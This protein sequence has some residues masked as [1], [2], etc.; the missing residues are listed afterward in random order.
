MSDDQPSLELSEEPSLELS[1]DSADLD[2]F[3]VVEE[4]SSMELPDDFNLDE[5]PELME[6]SA[7]EYAKMGDVENDGGIEFDLDSVDLD[8]PE[9]DVSYEV[10]EAETSSMG[11][12]EDP[13]DEDLKQ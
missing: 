10:P 11:T 4:D 13:E 2:E 6:S 5:E 1:E 8:E 9:E 12:P 7:E 3:N